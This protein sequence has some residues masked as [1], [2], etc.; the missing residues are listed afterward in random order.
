MI[1]GGVKLDCVFGVWP[2]S[3]SAYCTI[4]MLSDEVPHVILI[5]AVRVTPVRF[6]S[7]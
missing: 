4:V 6:D 7:A 2:S 1:Y 5:I 3:P